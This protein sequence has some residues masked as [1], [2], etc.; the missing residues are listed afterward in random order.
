MYLYERKEWPSLTWD[1]QSL[2]TLHAAVSRQQGRLE[3]PGP[4]SGSG[5]RR[6]TG[7]NAPVETISEPQQAA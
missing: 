5:G 1:G 2:S 7:A 3:L 4:M 6:T